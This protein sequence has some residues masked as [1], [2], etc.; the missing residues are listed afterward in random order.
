MF[1]VNKIVIEGYE[2]LTYEVF[3]PKTTLFAVANDVGYIMCAALDIDFFNNTP[4]LIERKIIA[5][6]AEGVRSIEHLLDFPLAK[7]T[8]AA[9]E[10]GIVPGTTGRDALVLMAQSQEK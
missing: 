4:K 5:G 10:I 9:E 6:R 7:V 3:L 1:N 8:L 2:F